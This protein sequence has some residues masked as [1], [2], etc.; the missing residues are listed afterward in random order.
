MALS[1]EQMIERIEQSTRRLPTDKLIEVLDFV[2]FLV[3]RHQVAESERESAE[4]I[5]PTLKGFR[6]EAG[7]VDALL[8]DVEAARSRPV[9]PAQ[10]SRLASSQSC[11]RWVVSRPRDAQECAV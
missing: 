4:A 7:E 8:N 3:Q 10:A 11:D 6:F 1:R 9:R 2:G 5:L